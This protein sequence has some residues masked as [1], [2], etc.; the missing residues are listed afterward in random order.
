MKFSLHSIACPFPF[1]RLL[2]T[3]PTG[4]KLVELVLFFLKKEPKT[5][6][7]RG[8]LAAFGVSQ[9]YCFCFFSGKEENDSK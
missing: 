9:S 2:H 3:G 1:V 4:L 5:L 7:L 8:S 6:A